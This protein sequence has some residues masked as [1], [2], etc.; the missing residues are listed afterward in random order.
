MVQICGRTATTAVGAA[1]TAVIQCSAGSWRRL[2]IAL[3]KPHLRLAAG[4]GL[5]LSLLALQRLHLG[6]HALQAPLR[7]AARLIRLSLGSRQRLRRLLLSRLAAAGQCGGCRSGA[8]H[9]AAQG[10][11]CQAR[12]SRGVAGSRHSAL[13]GGCQIHGRGSL[14][15]RG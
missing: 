13:G 4:R 8:H 6:A 5:Q 14:Q 15:R 11:Q 1:A 9:R 3:D 10:R 7:L 12:G 2:E